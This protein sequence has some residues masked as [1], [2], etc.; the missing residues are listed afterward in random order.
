MNEFVLDIAGR[1]DLR[2]LI[3]VALG[4]PCLCWLLS[5]LT[6]LLSFRPLRFT[7]I[8][9][10][11]L[12]WQGGVPAAT[13]AMAVAL[14]DVVL[15][16]T[17]LRELFQEL[18]PDRIADH[19]STALLARLDDHVDDIMREYDAVAWERLPLL[20]R[21]RIQARLR[22]QLPD[23]VDNIVEGLAE[24]I[25][26]LIDL[27]DLVARQVAADPSLM[28]RV[29][30]ESAAGDLRCAA[31]TS[32]LLGLPA[33]LLAALVLALRPELLP[34]V[35]ALSGLAASLLVPAILLRPASPLALGPF[36][37]QGLFLRHRQGIIERLAERSVQEVIN[38]DILM[39]EVL[40]GPQAHRTRAIIKRHMRLLLDSGSMR[41]TLQVAMGAE[42]YVEL[43]QRLADQLVA[44]ALESLADPR[45][46]QERSGIIHDMV[47]VRLHALDSVALQALLRPLLKRGTRFPALLCAALGGAAGG[48]LL[49]F[50]QMP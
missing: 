16:R 9:A 46:S 11:G 32:F 34:L 18:G 44:S 1:D 43:K 37:L 35:T 27:R 28:V 22:R 31:R 17:R 20:V 2:L 19:V 47:R 39:R 24:S 21:R 4:L 30:R 7:G 38:L 41:T 29:L 40:S 45:F 33:G 50:V 13:P 15:A 49:M 14:V 5:R 42:G 10:L 36:C 25:E 48:L 12:G 6:L 23:I 8:R 3:L 26:E